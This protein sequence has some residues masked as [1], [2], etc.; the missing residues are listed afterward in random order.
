MGTGSPSSGIV[1]LILTFWELEFHD[2]FLF[3][4]FFVFGWSLVPDPGDRDVCANAGAQRSAHTYN[5]CHRLCYAPTCG[6]CRAKLRIARPCPKYAK[7][8][9]AIVNC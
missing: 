9:I 1:R 6:I 5:M 4:A 8:L 2:C 3:R 7:K